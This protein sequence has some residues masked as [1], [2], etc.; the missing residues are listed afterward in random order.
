MEPAPK[1]TFMYNGD[2]LEVLKEYNYLE[3][4]F[5]LSGSFCKAKKHLCTHASLIG[6]VWY[7]YN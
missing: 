2:R 5:S 4:I 1:C 3:V 6:Y 7:M